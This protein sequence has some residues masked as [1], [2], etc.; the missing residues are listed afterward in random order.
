[1]RRR[2][3]NMSKIAFDY[4]N[5]MTIEALEDNVE[6]IVPRLV[7]YGIDGIGWKPIQGTIYASSGQRISIKYSLGKMEMFG[8][9]KISGKCNLCGNCMSLVFGDDAI[10]QKDLSRYIKCFYELFKGCSGICAVQT[11]F[12]PATTLA[13]HC[14]SYMFQDCIELTQ[15]PEL[16][17]TT[18]TNWCYSHMFQDCIGLTQA[19]ELPATTL[20]SNCYLSMFRGCTSL[21]NAP[22][23]PATTLVLS[24]YRWMFIHCTSLNVI[25]MLAT[26]ISASYCL[27]EW[28]D[29]VASTDGTFIKAASMTSL[30]SGDSGVPAGWTVVNDGEEN[31]RGEVKL[32]SFTIVEGI[33]PAIEVEY[34][35]IEGMTWVEWVDSEYNTGGYYIY[36]KR[37]LTP[38]GINVSYSDTGRGVLTDEVIISKKYVLN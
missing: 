18:L 16:P 13:A 5:Y 30:P 32:I 27:D 22:E 6:I 38:D 29:G 4:N 23:L 15:A 2:F 28:V 31:G 11:G 19:P 34:N 12:L 7:E 37:V 9:I 3:I 21:V 25:T 14:Y 20:A 35:A 26:D 33:F 36:D 10:N 1:M 17:A 24:C 8:N